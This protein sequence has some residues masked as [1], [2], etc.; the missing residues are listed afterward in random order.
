MRN[1]SLA[2]TQKLESNQSRSQEELERRQLQFKKIRDQNVYTQKKLVG[3]VLSK[4]YLRNL[5]RNTNAILEEQGFFR[6]PLEFDLYNNL[7]PWIY[8]EVQQDIAQAAAVEHEAGTVIQE[9]ETEYALRHAESISHEE[10]R[11]KEIEKQRL[12]EIDR[13]LREKEERK[14]QK[15][16][17]QEEERLRQEELA[18]QQAGDPNAPPPAPA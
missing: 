16:R 18:A 5:H 1:A 6:E 10:R 7:L 4:Q 8:Q 15:L 9:F 13:K 2:E 11:R 3:R 14:A 17:E 12:D